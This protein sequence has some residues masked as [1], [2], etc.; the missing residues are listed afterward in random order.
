MIGVLNPFYFLR[1]T[2]T[3][4]NVVF[5]KRPQRV[6]P[7]R[8]G[9]KMIG[10]FCLCAA[11]RIGTENPRKRHSLC[12]LSRGCVCVVLI[13]W[14]QSRFDGVLLQGTPWSWRLHHLHGPRQVR[15]WGT[16]Q[17]WFSRR[18]LVNLTLTLTPHLCFSLRDFVNFLFDSRNWCM[19]KKFA[20]PFCLVA[21][22]LIW[23]ISCLRNEAFCW[24]FAPFRNLGI[25]SCWFGEEFPEIIP[26][27]V[28]LKLRVLFLLL[29]V[30]FL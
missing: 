13:A 19:G 15:E 9:Q 6:F 8:K 17:I 3:Q 29:R 11:I 4:Q 1:Y 16:H 7:L 30:W 22:W 28:A 10:R 26:W 2:Y 14:E 24:L 25:K 18:H 12:S 5:V 23:L 20:C 27:C 21:L